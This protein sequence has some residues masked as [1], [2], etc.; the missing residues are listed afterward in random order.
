LTAT[1]KPSSAKATHNCPNMGSSSSSKSS[2]TATA[3]YYSLT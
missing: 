1:K 2:S 3:G